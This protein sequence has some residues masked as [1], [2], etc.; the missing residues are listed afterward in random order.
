VGKVI[1]A[2]RSFTFFVTITQRRTYFTGKGWSDCFN[3][4]SP[5]KLHGRD[6]RPQTIQLKRNG[7]DC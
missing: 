5:Y 7:K 2:H 3:S 6:T 1:H 4:G